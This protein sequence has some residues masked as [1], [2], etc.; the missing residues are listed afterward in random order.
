MC[1]K[2]YLIPSIVGEVVEYK[3]NSY[4]LVNYCNMKV[5]MRL[6]EGEPMLNYKHIT[7]ELMIL[8]ADGRYDCSCISWINIIISLMIANKLKL[9]YLAAMKNAEGYSTYNLVKRVMGV[10]TFGVQSLAL[11]RSKEMR[12]V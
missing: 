3:S 4:A 8:Q 6:K 1:M 5:I 2:N 12:E 11:G 7:T 10:V 9:V